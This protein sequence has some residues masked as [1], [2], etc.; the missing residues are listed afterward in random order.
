MATAHLMAT[1]AARPAPSP[2]RH[3]PRTRPRRPSGV[4]PCSA[5]EQR[6]RPGAAAAAGSSG[7]GRAWRAA[8]RPDEA[9]G[10]T[11]FAAS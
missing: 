9:K 4:D 3:T 5:R 7:S 1:Q 8:P 10:V 6:Q 11:G 2:S